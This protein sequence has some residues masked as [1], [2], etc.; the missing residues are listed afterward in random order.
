M[1][2][3]RI[4]LLLQLADIGTTVVALALGG[5]EMNPLI[6]RF[7]TVGVIEGLIVSKVIVLAIGLGAARFGRYAG[8]RVVNVFFSGVVV[9]NLIIIV[10]LSLH[11]QPV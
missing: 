2:V 6:A 7:M 11:A 1:N 4:F 8:L 10:R 5:V 3:L 9:W